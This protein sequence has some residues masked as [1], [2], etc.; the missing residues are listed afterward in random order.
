MLFYSNFY[1]GGGDDTSSGLHGRILSTFLNEL[2]GV[3][4]GGTGGFESS[5]LVL[6]AC[7]DLST[8]DEALL[9]PG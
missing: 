2:D 8:L 1:R 6:A 3:A 9:R 4:G 7:S 5:V